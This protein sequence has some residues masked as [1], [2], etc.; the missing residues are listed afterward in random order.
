MK[1]IVPNLICLNCGQKMDMV[2]SIVFD[3]Y[4]CICITDNIVYEHND[5]LLCEV[6][7]SDIGI[8]KTERQDDGDD[9]WQ[10]SYDNICSNP[11][12]PKYKL[13]VIEGREVIKFEY[14]TF[15]KIG[16]YYYI[17]FDDKVFDVYWTVRINS[18]NFNEFMDKVRRNK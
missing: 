11:K 14:M 6:C 17:D 9:E 15:K 7:N 5:S 10:E 1:E 2:Y 18:N 16:E 3:R 4:D 12:C 13:D 8:I